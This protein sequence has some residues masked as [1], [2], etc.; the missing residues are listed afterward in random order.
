MVGDA[1]ALT[2]FPFRPWVKWGALSSAVKPS[3]VFVFSLFFRL[4]RQPLTLFAY[5]YSPSYHHLTHIPMLSSC[6][7]HIIL[8]SPYQYILN[9]SSK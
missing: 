4:I 1:D 2:G 3:D 6:Y 9:T 7:L 5:P 8:L